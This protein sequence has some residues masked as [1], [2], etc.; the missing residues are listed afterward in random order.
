M[1]SKFWKGSA[2]RPV[3]YQD[4]GSGWNHHRNTY[5]LGRPDAVYNTGSSPNPETGPANPQTRQPPVIPPRLGDL[6]PWRGHTTQMATRPEINTFRG[7]NLDVFDGHL[8]GSA[9]IV[10]GLS[11]GLLAESSALHGL[12]RQLPWKGSQPRLQGWPRLQGS[13]QEFAWPEDYRG[14]SGASGVRYTRVHN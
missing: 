13:P 3:L 11:D 7:S 2:P 6:A 1:E 14:A 4:N 8:V 9:G 12:P 5:L 10:G